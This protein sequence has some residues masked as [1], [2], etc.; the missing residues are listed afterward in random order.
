MRDVLAVN[1]LA[2]A[3]CSQL[4]IQNMSK[5]HFAG[6]VVN[7]GSLSG[8]R[9]SSSKTGFYA[10][11]KACVRSITEAL[12][13]EMRELRRDIRITHVSPG[14]VE[15]EF[16]Q[17]FFGSEARAHATYATIPVLRPEDVADAILYALSCPPHMEVNDVLI[18]PTRQGV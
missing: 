4:A 11:S 15:T 10:A 1:V 5:R 9:V 7:V 14:V 18:R 12:R 3:Q 13:M 6:H 16:H 8:H 2:V 17:H